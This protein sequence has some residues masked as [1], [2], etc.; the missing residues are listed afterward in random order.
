MKTTS[1][2]I[3]ENGIVMGTVMERPKFNAWRDSQE[4]EDQALTR[5]NASYRE[6]EDQEAIKDL[7]QWEDHGYHGAINVTELELAIEVEEVEQILDGKGHWV[8]KKD[9]PGF[10]ERTVYRIVD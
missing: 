7:I 9:F 10:H 8:K 6:F 5:F 2:L 1:I 4:I 3:N